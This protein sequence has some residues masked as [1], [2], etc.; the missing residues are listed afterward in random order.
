MYVIGIIETQFFAYLQLIRHR[1]YLLNKLL[2]HL[3]K[4]GNPNKTNINNNFPTP[5]DEVTQIKSN[6]FE[7]FL[8]KNNSLAMNEMFKSPSVICTR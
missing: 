8:S 5:V 6:S 2:I 3:G 4:I 7:Y 1:L